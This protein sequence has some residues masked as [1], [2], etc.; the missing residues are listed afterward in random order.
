MKT[1]RLK[2][3]CIV[4]A[5]LACASVAQTANGPDKPLSPLEKTLI[6]N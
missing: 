3:L 6:A 4:Y 1:Q 2:Y 5:L